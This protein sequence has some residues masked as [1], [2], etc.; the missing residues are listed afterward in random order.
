MISDPKD[1]FL[2]SLPAPS[3]KRNLILGMAWGLEINDL[4]LFCKSLRRVMPSVDVVLLTKDTPVAVQQLAATYNVQLLPLTSCYYGLSISSPKRARKETLK[5]IRNYFGLKLVRG[6]QR[7]AYPLLRIGYTRQECHE[8][9]R[10]VN[11]LVVHTYGSRFVQYLDFLK[12]REANYAKVM[13]TDVR[14]VY[15]QA[16]PFNRIP[17]N[18]LWMFQE[19]GPALLGKEKRNR[20]WIEATFGKRVLEQIAHQPVICAGITLGGFQNVLGYLGTMEPEV[21]RR[22]PVYIPDQ[23]IHNA[24]AYTG[25]FNHLNPVIVKNAEG[26]V[27]TVGM[28]KDAEIVLDQRGLVVDSSGNPYPVIHQYDRHPRLVAAL[29]ALA[30]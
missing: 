9:Q 29:K 19:H 8:L 1:P 7:A 11:K 16:D 2:S 20:K 4:L 5:R 24:L 3:G 26:P 13:L 23:G 15:F 25:A 28:M 12:N 6:L 30:Q 17:D 10:E 18:Q 27:L 21:L 22:T 14:D